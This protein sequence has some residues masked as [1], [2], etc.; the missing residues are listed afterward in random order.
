MGP[1]VTII[2]PVSNIIE[3]NQLDEFNLLLSL[4]D[5]QT[6]EDIEHLVIDNASTDGTLEM[7]KDYKN[8]GFLNF[9]SEKDSGKVNAYNKG[10]MH[11]K[12]KYVTFL[13]CDDFIHDI[14]A[15]A[16]IVNLMEANNADF[17]FAPAYCRHPEGFVFLFNPSMYNAFQVMPCAKQ[18]MFFKKSTLEK[19]GYFDE[20]FKLLADLDMIIRLIMH[21]RTAVAFDNNYVTYKLAEKAMNNDDRVIAESKSIF[22][23]NFRNLHPLNEQLLDKM[24]NY[25]EF[26]QALVEKLSQFF[27]D[28]DKELFFEKFEQMHNLRVEAIKNQARS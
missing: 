21:K 2:T 26:P 8:K 6:Y 22:Y 20:K 23:K 11:A 9:Y 16:D 1:T 4:L 27:P 18:A 28:S 13:S 25:S 5:L 7:L 24:A 19:E 17:T 12:G 3:K 15:V 14:T 10:I